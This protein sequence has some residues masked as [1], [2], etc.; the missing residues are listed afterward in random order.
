M[1]RPL[2][3]HI[4]HP[5][6][7]SSTLQAAL[8]RCADELRGSGCLVAN[9]T[10]EFPEFGPPGPP[11]VQYI[12][13]T[14][15][16]GESGLLEV[17]A[18]FQSL[19][20]HLGA[21]TPRLIVSAES[22]S[23]P[24]A[25]LLGRA[26]QHAFEI[27]VVYYIRRQDEWLISAWNQWGTKEGLGLTG[28]CERRLALSQPNF[29][30]VL[31]RWEPVADTLRVRP[32]HPA[33]LTGGSIVSDFFAAVGAVVEVPEDARANA[34]PDLA[35]LEVFASSPFLFESADD[36]T[37]RNWLRGELPPDY[38]IERATLSSD[39]LARIRDT[40]AAG[41]RDLHARFFAD[42]DYDAVFGP[43]PDEDARLRQH[44]A[45]AL[46]TSA[47]ERARRTIGLQFKMM[48][49]MHL[50]LSRLESDESRE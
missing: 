28:F 3:L 30:K 5:K 32:L 2:Y 19:E 1:R 20:Q 26:L 38:P 4:G 27:H 45:Q 43:W 46:P 21:R 50:R 12:A 13:D 22:L 7:A 37:V 29:A 10:M 15:D 47:L 11:P 41:N 42:V 17:V 35:L 31:G 14:V 23:K 33:A 9:A 6:T 44:A 25:E 18:K 16:R 24:G 48:H 36:N 40:F 49:D 8:I 39:L 34:S